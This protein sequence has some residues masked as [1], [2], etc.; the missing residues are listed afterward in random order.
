MFIVKT[1]NIIIKKQHFRAIIIIMFINILIKTREI[2]C[3]IN[4]KIERNFISQI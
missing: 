2:R 1:L 4:F 3:L